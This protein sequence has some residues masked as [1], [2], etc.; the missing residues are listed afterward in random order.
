MPAIQSLMGATYQSGVPQSTLAL[1]HL[2]VSQLNGCA[3]C[4][5]MGREHA[6]SLGESED[7][8]C[9]ATTSPNASYWTDAERAALRLA[10]SITRLDAGED[11]VP[12]EVWEEAARHYDERALAGLVLSIGMTNLFN[13]VN[14]AT[15][16]DGKSW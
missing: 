1:V 15:R 2:R 16:Q 10:D 3:V 4:L 12:D 6:K 14:I 7:R 8:I 9:A 13:R 11:S 5:A